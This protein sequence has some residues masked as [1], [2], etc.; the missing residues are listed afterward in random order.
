[1]STVTRELQ[2]N[3]SADGEYRPHAAQ[4]MMR[5]RR[6]RPKARLLASDGELLEPAQQYLDQR[7]SPEQ[8]VHELE[9]THAAASRSKRSTK[10]R[11]GCPT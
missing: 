11:P 6:P 9:V 8:I 7:W 2:R 1:L 3:Q 4:A 5:S 10:P